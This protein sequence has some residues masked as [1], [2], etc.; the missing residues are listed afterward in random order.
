MATLP[1]NLFSINSLLCIP[2][3]NIEIVTSGY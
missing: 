2:V 1:E 3:R